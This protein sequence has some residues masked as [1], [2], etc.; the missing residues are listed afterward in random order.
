VPGAEQEVGD[1]VSVDVGPLS[2]DE[3]ADVPMPE[4]VD[5]VAISVLGVSMLRGRVRGGRVRE[6]GQQALVAGDDLDD[7]VQEGQQPVPVRAPGP[8]GGGPVA[9]ASSSSWARSAMS[10]YISPIRLPNRWNT[11][12]LP[13][14][15]SAAT[16]SIEVS[17]GRRVA[18]SFSV[19]ARIARRFLIAS[20]RSLRLGADSAG[21]RWPWLLEAPPADK[22]TGGP[23]LSGLS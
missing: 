4:P 6:L 20:A 22:L 10:A 15:A 9:T 2:G 11:V 21:S 19:A 13:T 12:P 14:P 23:A 8:S 16:C 17:R 7:G 1:Q 18:S 3:P 5:R